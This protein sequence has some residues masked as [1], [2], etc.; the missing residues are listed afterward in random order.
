MKQGKVKN[1]QWKEVVAWARNWITQQ[2]GNIL[3]AEAIEETQQRCHQRHKRWEPKYPGFHISYPPISAFHWI[4]P[5][6]EDDWQRKPGKYS[7]QW[8]V[9][10]WCGEEQ[11]EEEANGTWT[12][13]DSHPNPDLDTFNFA[14]SSS[15]HS[16]LF[17]VS[18]H[19]CRWGYGWAVKKRYKV[20]AW[21][22]QAQIIAMWEVLWCFPESCLVN[23][24]PPHTPT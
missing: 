12:S 24:P 4:E 14:K 2:S 15:F 20:K 21:R 19:N 11:G 18:L 16:S 10:L 1:G 3:T 5:N 13:T 8:S 17:Y 9:N 22:M 7:L 6:P 23:P